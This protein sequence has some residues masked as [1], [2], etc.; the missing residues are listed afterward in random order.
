MKK[1]FMDNEKV[2]NVTYNTIKI[3]IKCII[4][5]F[6]LMIIADATGYNKTIFMI[7]PATVFCIAYGISLLIALI[8]VIVILI[9]W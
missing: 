8:W 7:I 1:Q 6:A 9:K 4:F 3:L 5:S 2:I